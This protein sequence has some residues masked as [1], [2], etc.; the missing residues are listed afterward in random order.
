MHNIKLKYFHINDMS[1]VKYTSR[2]QL[3]IKNDKVI[4]HLQ[5]TRQYISKVKLSC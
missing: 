4:L 2:L 3:R 5:S 1:H